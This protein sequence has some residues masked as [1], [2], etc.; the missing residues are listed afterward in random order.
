MANKPIEEWQ[1]PQFLS[2]K[3]DKKWYILAGLLAIATI[4]IALFLKQWL[5][6]VVILTA[7]IVIFS[8]AREQAP[9]K[10]ISISDAGIGI[11]GKFYTFNQ[12][13]SFWIVE[14]PQVKTMY[15]ETTKR[16]GLPVSVHFWGETE[17][18]RNVLVRHLP[19][20]IRGEELPD[21]INRII[22]F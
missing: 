14:H 19:E 22:R 9:N 13:K 10:K 5:F 15:L 7:T 3:K 4:G 16:F 1:A 18:I 8:F 17:R 21:L 12:L 11:N 6:A 20:Q 2:F